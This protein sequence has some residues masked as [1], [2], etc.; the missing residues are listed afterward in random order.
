MLLFSEEVDDARR[1]RQ[2]IRITVASVGV[3]WLIHFAGV[4]F[5]LDLA[6]FGIYPRR[7]I[8]IPGI[9][10]A[11]LIHG[12]FAHLLAN[13][14]AIVVLGTSLLYGYP[15]A[16][17][18]VI[19]WLYAGTGLGVWLFARDG[20]HIGASGLAFGMMFFVFTIGAIRWDR[21]AIALSMLAFFLYG[22]MVWGIFPTDPEVSFESH[23]FGA[24]LGVILAILL[25]NR[26]PAP[27]EPGY[28]WEEGDEG[29]GE[30]EAGAQPDLPDNE[31]GRGGAEPPAVH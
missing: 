27:P 28:A 23:F 30:G 16:A 9:A 17:G 20:C 10:L 31:S 6:R 26:D 15:R 14:T 11:P 1:F 21:R 4:L 12:S 3:L 13:S 22:G 8:G 2:A 25:R 29:R 7:A 19:K 5:D 18:S 24:L